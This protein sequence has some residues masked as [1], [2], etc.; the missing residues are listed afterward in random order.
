MKKIILIL[1][2][3]IFALFGYS[4][5]EGENI[6]IDNAKLNNRLYGDKSGG[7]DTLIVPDADSLGQYKYMNML[8]PASDLDGV[9][10][11]TL[12]N[13]G[14]VG[15]DSISFENGYVVYWVAGSV[16]D[17]TISLDVRYLQYSDT[18]SLVVTITQ[19]NDSLDN[20]PTNL[21]LDTALLGL[22]QSVY[23]ITLP[24]NG[25]LSGSVAAAVEGTDYPTGWV[26]SASGVNLLIEH[27][28]S[29][30]GANVNV[31]YNISSTNYKFLRPFVDAYQGW[32]NLDDDNVRIETIST[33]YTQSI[34][35]IYLL[36][37]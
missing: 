3:L 8:D 6:N 10:L 16:S 24:I 1:G 14:L 25:T 20:Y 4:Q 33:R 32:T 26:L 13:S 23:N 19:L 37:E 21:D 5:D 2:L 27:N 11:R 15:I 7:I 31:S 9:N 17:S 35:K 28:L 34:L 18:T 29:R 36:L 22:T 30:H 12:V